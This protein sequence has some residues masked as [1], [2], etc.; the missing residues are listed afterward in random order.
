M[1]SPLDPPRTTGE[2]AIERYNRV[3]GV[4]KPTGDDMSKG[5][6]NDMIRQEVE[7]EVESEA[8]IAPP[9]KRQ[10]ETNSTLQAKLTELTA[11]LKTSEDKCK[12][13]EEQI[14]NLELA[15]QQEKERGDRLEKEREGQRQLQTLLEE[16]TALVEQLSGRLQQ[17]ESELETS[18]QLVEKLYGRIQTLE[19]P[20]APKPESAPKPAIR[21]P[22]LYNF[23]VRTLAR[24]VAPTPAS[25]EL[26]DTDIGWFD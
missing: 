12:T 26:T 9:P 17:S 24:Y 6:L 1:R 22:S 20:P 10:R 4:T 23:E 15:L 25:T 14:K 7:K 18:Q 11:K 13:L 3:C 16:Q 21:K 19:H 5:N 8:S 2:V